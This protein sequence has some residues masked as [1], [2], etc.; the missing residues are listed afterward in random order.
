MIKKLIIIQPILPMEQRRLVKNK[1]IYAKNPK[2][3]LMLLVINLT[4]QKIIK[5]LINA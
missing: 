4:F 1:N 3:Y 2:K 5:E